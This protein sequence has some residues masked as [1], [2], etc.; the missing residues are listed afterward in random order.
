MN[1]NYKYLKY[2][3]KNIL[4][5]GISHDQETIRTQ[6]QKAFEDELCKFIYEQIDKFKHDNSAINITIINDKILLNGEK[7]LWTKIK[8]NNIEMQNFFNFRQNL[9]NELV[10][11]IFSFFGCDTHIC[12][13]NPTGSV[14]SDANLGSDYDLTIIDN[15]FYAALMIQIFNSIF[16]LTFGVTPYEAFDTNLYGYSALI[17]DNDKFA[18]KKIWLLDNFKKHYYLPL[19]TPNKYQ[20]RWALRRLITFIEGINLPFLQIDKTFD[21]IDYI[22]IYKI[23]NTLQQKLYIEKM[24]NF[25]HLIKYNNDDKIEELSNIE[26]KREEIANA[27]SFMNYYGDET[28]FTIGAFMHVVGTM[29][30]Y[31]GESDENKIVFLTTTHLIHSMIE[32][33]AYF[34]HSIEKSHDIIISVKYLERFMDAYKL[35]KLK[36]KSSFNQEELFI[37]MRELKSKFRNATDDSINK[38]L[39]EEESKKL[40]SERILVFNIETIKQNKREQLKSLLLILCTP[41]IKS[42]MII[43]THDNSYIFYLL[44]LLM[45][46]IKYDNT[47]INISYKDDKF[48]I[49]LP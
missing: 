25:E 43:P 10:K 28:Y 1:Y 42:Y 48:V 27:L 36:N 38:Y 12:I 16:E 46:V 33:L 22:N 9:V 41:L 15:T 7:W 3:N 35:S 39:L 23:E 4:I 40:E 19:Q 34:I 31:R 26:I 13:S 8:E 17:P 49:N 45:D 24:K 14:G 21:N 29:F 6:E 18:N 32:N 11:K 47:F 30:Y 2:K 44:L 37:L 5:G 20:D